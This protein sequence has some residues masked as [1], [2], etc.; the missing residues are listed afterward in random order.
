M[1]IKAVK[2][3]DNGFMTQVLAFGG[4]GMDGIDPTVRYR[5]SLQNYVAWTR[6]TWRSRPC[7]RKA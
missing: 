2:L 5:S 4:E 1:K 7:R 3:Y 6:S